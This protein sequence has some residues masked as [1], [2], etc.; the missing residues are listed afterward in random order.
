MVPECRS[1]ADL[2]LEKLLLLADEEYSGCAARD[3]YT[4]PPKWE[5]PDADVEGSTYA[6]AKQLDVSDV[7]LALDPS[8]AFASKQGVCVFDMMMMQVGRRSQFE[9]DSDYNEDD[10][11][12]QRVPPLRLTLSASRDSATKINGFQIGRNQLGPDLAS[13]LNHNIARSKHALPQAEL[14]ANSRDSIIIARQVG[15]RYLWID[16][17]C[18]LQDS[19]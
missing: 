1:C 8:T 3:H 2:T 5:G 13:D 18:I 19:A 11:W 16:S 4:W 9:D 7:T 17:L 12:D 14:P 15:I 6:A 10:Y